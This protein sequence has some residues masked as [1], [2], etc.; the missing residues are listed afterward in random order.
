MVLRNPRVV[1]RTNRRA[2]KESEACG[3]SQWRSL[4]TSGNSKTGQRPPRGRTRADEPLTVLRDPS[5]ALA[6]RWPRRAWTGVAPLL[7]DSSESRGDDAMNDRA[8]ASSSRSCPD[9]LLLEVHVWAGSS[10]R[11]SSD[12]QDESLVQRVL[13][14]GSWMQTD[15]SPK[16]PSGSRVSR[17]FADS[18]PV[19]TIFGYV[20]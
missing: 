5:G 17:E 3:A 10:L 13:P 7:Q 8:L 20:F 9:V 15:D 18:S 14:G 19:S 1:R 16:N 12:G 11:W 6:R 4:G 2:V